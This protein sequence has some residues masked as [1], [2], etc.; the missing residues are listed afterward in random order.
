MFSLDSQLRVYGYVGI[1]ATPRKPE[2]RVRDIHH[3]LET[4]E[5]LG[6]RG[7]HLGREALDKVLIDNAVGLRV[8]LGSL[9]NHDAVQTWR[10]TAAKKARTCSIKYRSLSF[11]LFSQSCKS[12]ARLISSDVQKDA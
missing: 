4:V 5:A 9:G 7:L 11:N 12:A 2:D 3:D 8:S 1:A 6:L 10:L